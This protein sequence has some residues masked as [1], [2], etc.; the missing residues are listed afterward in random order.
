MCWMTSCVTSVRGQDAA[1][2]S[3]RSS[4]LMSL[5]CSTTASIAGHRSTHDPDGNSTNRSSRREQTGPERSHS[6]G[7]REILR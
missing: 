1:E 7:P 6:D 3:L 2:S 5:A 4:A